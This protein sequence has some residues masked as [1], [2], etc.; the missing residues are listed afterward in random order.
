MLK[1]SY[2]RHVCSKELLNDEPSVA[3]KDDSSNVAGY[4]YSLLTI[5]HSP[6]HTWKTPVL[7]DGI[8]GLWFAAWIPSEISLRVSAGS[9]ISST[10]KR[11]A[12]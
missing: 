7:N 10:H 11:A 4:K 12:A 6:Y 2:S 5:D 9:I 3:T 1:R 8:N